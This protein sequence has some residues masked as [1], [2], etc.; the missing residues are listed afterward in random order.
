[1]CPVE[2]LAHGCGVQVV[3]EGVGSV[4]AAVG[5]VD[6][7]GLSGAE[8]GSGH[9]YVPVAVTGLEAD[10]AVDDGHRAAR[11]SA[12]AQRD[13]AYGPRIEFQ[14]CHRFSGGHAHGVD[15][16]QGLHPEVGAL[17]GELAARE[18]AGILALVD[19]PYFEITFLGFPDCA[20]NRLEPVVGEIFEG[21]VVS[22]LENHGTEALGLDGVEVVAY[23]LDVHGA[24]PAPDHVA[25][26]IR[27]RGRE[28]RGGLFDGDMVDALPTLGP[29]GNGTPCRDE[30]GGQNS[31]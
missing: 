29:G 21:Q 19:D 13:G 3:A 26:E 23:G 8:V 10:R 5:I 2:E 1:M 16:N 9:E 28:I 6:R 20:A 18:T 24:F 15:G 4:L 25:G 11:L 31:G 17:F 7:P 27:R 12:A 22:G 14:S 30:Q